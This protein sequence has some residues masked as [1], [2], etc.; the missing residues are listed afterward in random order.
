MANIYGL[1]EHGYERLGVGSSEVTSIPIREVM[2]DDCWA[3]IFRT[4]P[5]RHV[6]ISSSGLLGSVKNRLLLI[7]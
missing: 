1:S 5:W 7:T 3:N 6:H 2:V 4:Q